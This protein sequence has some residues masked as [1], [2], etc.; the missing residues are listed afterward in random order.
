[1]RVLARALAL[2]AVFAMPTVANAQFSYFGKNKPWKETPKNFYQSEHFDVYHPLDLTDPE[3]KEHFVRLT[4]ELE[5]AYEFLS[6]TFDHTLKVRPNVIVYR[7]HS[8]FESTHI[9]DYMFLPEG[10]GAFADPQKNRLVIK[11]DFLPPLDCTIRGH[12]L[13]HIFQFDMLDLNLLQRAVQ[14]Y[15][16]P[17]WFI[18]G[19]ADYWAGRY[20]PYTRDDIR[21]ISQR[22]VAANPEKDLPTWE[23]MKRG[24]IDAYA[25]GAMMFEFI[26]DTFGQDAILEFSMRTLKDRSMPF[27]E[28]FQHMSKGKIDTPETLDRMH[29]E[30]WRKRFEREWGKKQ[31]PYEDTPSFEGRF[32]ITQKF[33]FPISSI[34]VS[35]DGKT[36]AAITFHRK[37]GIVVATVPALPREDPE[38]V[39]KDKKRRKIGFLRN[40]KVEKKPED[41]IKVLTPFGI[42]TYEEVISQRLNTWPFNGSDVDWSKDG[43]MLAFFARKNKDHALFVIDAET[44]GTILHEIELPLDQAFSPAFSPNG[45]IVYFSASKNL[46]RDIYSVNLKTGDVRNITNDIVF[47]TAPAVSPDGKELVYVSF[48]GDFQKLFKLNLLTGQ[49]KQITF[50]RWNE[51]APFYGD[52]GKSIYFT[53]DEYVAENSDLNRPEHVWNLYTLELA[54]GEVKQWTDFYGGVFTPKPIPGEPDRVAY[55]GYWQYDQYKS[56]IYNNYELFDAKLKSP[57]RTYTVEDKKEYMK[58]AFRTTESFDRQPDK[59]QLDKPKKAPSKWKFYG[60]GVSIGHSTY[61]GTWGQSR[62]LWTDIFEER[63]H[64]VLFA[65][66][67]SGFRV[68]DYTYLNRQN[69]WA[70]AFALSEHKYPLYYEYYDMTRGRPEQPCTSTS[71]ECPDQITLGSARID[72]KSAMIVTQYPF[73]KWRRVE[74]GFS[75][76]NRNYDFINLDESQL[77][78]M[79]YGYSPLDFEF[80]KLLRDADGKTSF[81]LYSAFVNDTVLFSGS[82]MG[83]LRGDAFRLEANLAP[84]VG[85]LDGYASG[86]VEWRKY[87]QIGMTRG[88]FAFRTFGMLSDKSNGDFVLL[89]G[90][91]T[92]STHPYGSIAGNIVGY[93]RAELRFPLVDAVLLPGIGGFGPIRGFF[94]GDYGRAKFT[95]GIFPAQKAKTYGFG[96][97]MNFIMPMNF[98]WT[99]T[100]FEQKLRFGFYLGW[101]F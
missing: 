1:M 81:G 68:F 8:A 80:S 51:D 94:F 76:R 74:M 32:G 63:M 37:H 64:S 62:L 58:Y 34:A 9:I 93:A 65:R 42:T 43:K 88:L 56:Y 38:Y 18:E 69:R 45:E 3:Q 89:G 17:T 61:W 10:V 75:L 70:W 7:T 96:F 40:V 48:V 50:N 25:G 97:R 91:D 59:Q 19:M 16:I 49:K 55:I 13:V 23:H 15:A 41:F 85:G 86:S 72:E 5:K 52:D 27:L 67:G 33:P 99:K 95:N 35:P 29:R 6:S 54:T 21:R 77:W 26:R 39:P 90:N 92:F 24:S 82:T 83:P 46:T 79:A 12:E 101:A 98:V 20:R 47:D 36:I 22:G 57:L 66:Y 11:P 73:N 14:R 31:K 53:S 28:R 4:N 44:P 87:M 2:I 71:T 78:Y 30:Y 100:D 60:R 84:S